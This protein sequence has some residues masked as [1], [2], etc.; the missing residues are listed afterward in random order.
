MGYGVDKIRL[1]VEQDS[2]NFKLTNIA[3]VTTSMSFTAGKGKQEGTTMEG[4]PMVVDP[5]WDGEVLQCDCTSVSG[6]ELSCRRQYFMDKHLVV[7]LVS[8]KGVCA[9]RFYRR[10]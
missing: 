5:V 6:E 8:V 7:D 10:E 3:R 1:V 4:N 2:D 9:K